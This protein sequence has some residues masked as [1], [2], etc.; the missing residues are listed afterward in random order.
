MG[1][2][3]EEARPRRSCCRALLLALLLIQLLWIASCYRTYRDYCRL[4]GKIRYYRDV[5]LRVNG[6]RWF[7]SYS[8][9]HGWEYRPTPLSQVIEPLMPGGTCEHRWVTVEDRRVLGRARGCLYS[10]PER[11]PTPFSAMYGPSPLV[12]WLTASHSEYG[13]IVERDPELALRATEIFLWPASGGQ[14]RPYIERLL[15]PE[16]GLFGEL[17]PTDENLNR[18]RAMVGLPPLEG[19]RPVRQEGLT[20]LSAP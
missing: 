19:V 5:G 1:E 8:L 7:T 12:W 9:P 10:R 15:D 13:S 16:T 17:A 2:E 18:W 4:C 3:A 20:G 14:H 6:P 11:V